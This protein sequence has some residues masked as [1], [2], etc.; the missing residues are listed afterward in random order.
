[1][2]HGTKRLAAGVAVASVSLWCVQLVPAQAATIMEPAVTATHAHPRLVWHTEF[3]GPAGGRPDPHKWQVMV[4][5][6]KYNQELEYYSGRPGNISLNGRGDLAITA[7][8]QLLGGRRY[9]SG[10]VETL[11]RFHVRYG[12]IEAR[13]KFP[14]GVGLWPA[15]FMLGTNYPTVGWPDSG[16]IDPMEFQGQRPTRL[17]ATV[18]G[19]ATGKPNGWQQ[20]AFAYSTTPFSSRFHVY[21]MDWSPNKIV[22][23]LDGKPYGT[24]TAQNIHPGDLWV[25]NRPYFFVMDMAVGGYWVGPPDATTRFPATMLV[26]WVRVYS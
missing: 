5:P 12:R 13:V 1:L 14:A 2:I 7:R 18:H 8:R 3:N 11:G 6:G 10:K 9:T 25:F 23:T 24:V 21:G 22:F 4:Y 15:F 19:P 20:N 26:D 17:V 16:E